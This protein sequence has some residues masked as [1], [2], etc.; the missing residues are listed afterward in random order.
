MQNAVILSQEQIA[1]IAGLVIANLG[2]IVGAYVSVKVKIAKLEVQVDIFGKNLN[3]LGRM[4]RKIQKQ[5][6]NE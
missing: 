1:L 3:D 4:I 6:E 5:G 2:A